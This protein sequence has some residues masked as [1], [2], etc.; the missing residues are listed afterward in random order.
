PVT[1]NDPTEAAR[2]AAVARRV[3]GDDRVLTDHEPLMGSEDFSKILQRVPGAMAFI[4]ATP[5][6]LDPAT[7]PGVHAPEV[8]FDDS[9]LTAQAALLAG[10]AL[11]RLGNPP[12]V[13]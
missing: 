1:I 12:S 11:D 5:P 6:D 3:C 2:L 13:K 4:A 7:A 9:V 10:T 8:R